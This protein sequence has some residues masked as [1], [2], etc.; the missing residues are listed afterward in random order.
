MDAEDIQDGEDSRPTASKPYLDAL[1]EAKRIF[2]PYNEKCDSIDKLYASLEDM[3]KGKADRQFQIFWAN[4]EVLR[5]TIYSRPPVPV[6]TPRYTDRKELPRKAS[7]V[8]ERVLATDVEMDNLHSTLKLVRDDLARGA[9]GVPWVLDDG[10]CIH[11][12]RNDF[13]HEPARKWSEVGWVGRRAFL[14]L[15]R[16]K[17]R[18]PEIDST[19]ISFDYHDENNKTAKKAEVWEIWD[20]TEGRVVWIAKGVEDVLDEQPPLIDVKD[21]FPCPEPAYGTLEPGSLKPVPD[22]VYYRDQVDEINE[23]TARIS[24]LS[25]SLRLKGF[26]AA[27]VS[28]VGE[29]I[30]AAMKATDDKALLVPVSNFAALGG[31]GLKDSIVWLPVREVAEVITALVQLRKQLIEDVYEITGLSDIMRGQTEASETLGAQQLKSQYGSVRVRERQAEMIRVARDVLRIKGEVFAETYDIQSLLEMSQV[32]DIPTKEQANATL[33]QAQAQRKPIDPSKIVTVEQID[34]LF[35]SQKLR[36]FVLDIESDSTIQPDEQAEKQSRMEFVEAIGG[37]IQKAGPMVQ[38]QPQTAPFVAE[39]MKFMASGFR[40]GRELGAVIDDFADQLKQLAAQPKEQQP[41]PAAIKAQADAQAN[42]A[43]MQMEMQRLQMEMQT[44]TAD[45]ALKQREMAA[46]IQVMQ[47]EA[48][49]AQE[50]ARANLA[51]TQADIQ[52]IL[53]QTALIERGDRDGQP[54]EGAAA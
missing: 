36:P 48:L 54:N 18:F 29:A 32:T 12:D 33:M 51:K 5:P 7:E 35:K 2:G 3:A 25:E 39:T 46:K 45:A 37:F 26:Y 20:K 30:E 43:K 21:F 19:K 52:K 49:T 23:L 53:A 8:L 17:E 22:F 41:D 40:A 13:M 47:A 31:A 15:E 10:S 6:V 1:A 11:V 42:Q 9:R 14:T 27:G 34:A 24:S 50:Q 4:L 16:F 38:A 44:K 28:E